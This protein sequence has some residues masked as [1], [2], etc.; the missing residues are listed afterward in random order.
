MDEVVS[1]A[2]TGFSG[3]STAF[4]K[5]FFRQLFKPSPMSF[6]SGCHHLLRLSG[7]LRCIEHARMKDKRYRDTGVRKMRYDTDG[8]DDWCGR[9]DN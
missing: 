7:T 8:C 4:K 3:C 5:I 2:D 6:S 1:A 9:Y